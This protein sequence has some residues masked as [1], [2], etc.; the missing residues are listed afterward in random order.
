MSEQ[1]LEEMSKFFDKRADTYDNHMLNELD[2]E[3]FYDEIAKCIPAGRGIVK[4]LDLGCGTGLEIERFFEMYPD[5]HVT[6]VDLSPKMLEVFRKK[7]SN[8]ETQINLICNS[9]FDIEFGEEEFD[10]VLSTY[11][12]HHFSAELKL[13]LYKKIHHWLKEDGLYIEGDY[14]VKTIIEE[15]SFINES[16]RIRKENTT[17][18]GFYHYDIPFAVQT[19]IDLLRSAGFDKV[20]TYQ[21]W[22]NTSIFLCNKKCVGK[23]MFNFEDVAERFWNLPQKGIEEIN[24][25]KNFIDDII[26][27]SHTEKELVNHLTGVSSVFDAGAGSGRFSVF[28]AKRGI[29]VVHFDISESMI[30]IA[31][32]YAK[33]EGVYERIQFMMGRL[34]DLSAFSDES[35]DMVISFDAPISYTYP[36][37]KEVIKNL[38]RLTRNK[39]IL[40]VSSRLGSLP[41]HLNPIQ[42]AKY[43]LDKN[44]D[45]PLV[46]WYKEHAKV[47]FESFHVDMEKVVKAYKTGLMEDVESVRE[48]FLRGE[49]PWVVNYL[50]MADELKEILEENGV[51]VL[52]MAGPG[53]LS[54]SITDEV[55]VRMMNDEEQRKSFLDFCYEYD[56]QPSV[57]GM[58][59]DNLLVT[60]VKNKA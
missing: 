2:L 30:Q 5:A 49:T 23:S 8:K 1:R 4:L 19:Q 57:I 52:G 9:Y 47:A 40:S 43:I 18:A 12:L 20:K 54:R 51:S 31:K 33:Q 48:S 56:Q 24:R 22:D 6:G 26:L 29:S 27:K 25:E 45:D 3:V 32:D 7:F 44:S 59:K 53:A 36:N 15:R 10:F 28:L 46:K 14:A 21:E 42:K 39:I 58:G 35:F 13:A 55:L 38:V 41:Y 50:F 16:E 11:S 17:T 34:G 60:G 37:H